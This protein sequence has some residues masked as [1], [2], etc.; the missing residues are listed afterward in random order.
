EIAQRHNLI[1]IEDA[2]QA[3]GAYYKG[4]RVGTFGHAAAFSFYPGKN[5]GAAGDAGI[6]VT[7]NAEIAEKVRAMRNCG[8]RE[9]YNHITSPYNHRM[10]TIQAAVLSIKLKHLDNWNAARRE[11]AARYTE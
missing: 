5:L 2:C 1:V 6:M 9:K 4:K 7:N 8:Q 10:D 11:H 3:H